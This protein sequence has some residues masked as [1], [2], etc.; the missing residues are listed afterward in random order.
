MACTSGGRLDRFYSDISPGRR[1]IKVFLFD[2]A[3]VCVMK[4]QTELEP[5]ERGSVCCEVCKL[6]LDWR[7][8]GVGSGRSIVLNHDAYVCCSVA[9]TLS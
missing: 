7:T 2:R 3:R 1:S 6:W 9:E 8:E 4:S 5:S